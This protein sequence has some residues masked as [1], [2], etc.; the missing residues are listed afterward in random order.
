MNQISNTKTFPSF[1]YSVQVTRRQEKVQTAAIK[2]NAIV[3]SLFPKE[4]RQRLFEESSQSSV[5]E[6]LKG[7]KKKK[8][9]KGGKG[10]EYDVPKFRLKNFL[11]DDDDDKKK[12]KANDEDDDDEEMPEM[13]ESKPIADL[14]PNTTVMFAD[15]AGFTAWS[16][17]REPSQVFTLLETVYHAFDK[18]AK[19][20]KVF[21]V[22]TVGDC[23]GTFDGW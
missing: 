23:Y 15:I 16:S 1:F 9:K 19:K 10:K 5:L 8:N 3:S 11:D 2:S 17:E 22:E 6:K 20:R 14:F 12:G 13:F 21:K 7:K 18:L 4:I